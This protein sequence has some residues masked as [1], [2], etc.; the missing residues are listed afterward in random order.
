M[1]LSQKRPAELSTHTHCRLGKWY[2]E[3]EGHDC[4]SQLPGY[5]EIATPHK[6]VH[7]QGAKALE[8]FY[9]KDNGSTF[10]ALAAMEQASIDV[11]NNLERMVTSAENDPILICKRD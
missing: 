3:G 9:A 6:I 4:F 5:R 1:N 8:S 2:L 10:T 7:E 11:V